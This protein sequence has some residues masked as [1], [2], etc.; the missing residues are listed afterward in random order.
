[1]KCESLEESYMHHLNEKS[2]LALSKKQEM[3]E[4]VLVRMEISSFPGS[5]KFNTGTF[6]DQASLRY[7]LAFGTIEQSPNNICIYKVRACHN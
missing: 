4:N 7:F 2:K 6:P 1:M 5:W 3:P